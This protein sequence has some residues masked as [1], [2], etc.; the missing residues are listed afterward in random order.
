MQYDRLACR[1][2][3]GCFC[4]ELVPRQKIALVL[5]TLLRDHCSSRLYD[6]NKTCQQLTQIYRFKRPP[7]LAEVD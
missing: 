7:T 5:K 2:E 6:I 3:V 4:M 1:I